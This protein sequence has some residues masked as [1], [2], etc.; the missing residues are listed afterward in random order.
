MKPNLLKFLIVVLAVAWGASAFA[1]PN[2]PPPVTRSVTVDNTGNLYTV[3]GDTNFF[4]K[5]SALMVAAMRLAN[6]TNPWATNAQHAVV[7]DKANDIDQTATNKVN[8]LIANQFLLG[9][10]LAGLTNTGGMYMRGGFANQTELILDPNGGFLINSLD[11]NTYFQFNHSFILINAEPI[12]GGSQSSMQLD[13][14]GQFVAWTTNGNSIQLSGDGNN[15]FSAVDNDGATRSNIFAGPIFGNSGPFYGSFIGTASTATNAQ[16]ANNLNAN[17][18]TTN[19]TVYGSPAK[20]N[21]TVFGPTGEVRTNTG[22]GNNSTWN[23]GGITFGSTNNTTQTQVANSSTGA[24]FQASGL[25]SS[26]MFLNTNGGANFTGPVIASNLLTQGMSPGLYADT[27]ADTFLNHQGIWDLGVR[28][29]VE[30]AVNVFKGGGIWSNVVDVLPLQAMYGATNGYTLMGRTFAISNGVWQARGFG[31]TRSTN[32][33]TLTLPPMTNYSIGI[34]YYENQYGVDSYDPTANIQA[35]LAQLYNPADGGGTILSQWGIYRGSRINTSTTTDYIY[36]QDNVNCSSNSIN[37][38]LSGSFRRDGSAAPHGSGDFY[39]IGYSNGNVTASIN[40]LPATFDSSNFTNLLNLS[41]NASAVTTLHIG[42]GDTNWTKVQN[43]SNSYGAVVCSVVIFNKIID[44]NMARIAYKAMMDLEPYDTAT[45]TSGSSIINNTAGAASG[46]VGTPATNTLANVDAILNPDTLVIESAAPG[47]HMRDW[48]NVVQGAGPYY[49]YYPV[50]NFLDPRKYKIRNHVTDGPRNDAF[51]L[52]DTY[53]N[54]LNWF[55]MGMQPLRTNGVR[56]IFVQTP[57]AYGGTSVAANSNWIQFAL[58]IKTN[59]QPYRFVP[60]ANYVSSNRLAHATQDSPPVHPDAVSMIGHM[61]NVEM[62][63]LINGK[64]SSMTTLDGDMQVA[65]GTLVQDRSLTNMI[66]LP[67]VVQSADGNPA[68]TFD[69][70]QGSNLNASAIS[71]G[72]MAY[73]RL[74]ISKFPMTLASDQTVIGT[75]LTTVVLTNLGPGTYDVDGAMQVWGS[76]TGKSKCIIGFSNSVSIGSGST[77]AY[78]MDVAGGST[79]FT[80]PYNHTG[81][82]GGG[83]PN[84]FQQYSI[85]ETHL[86]VVLTSSNI[87]WVQIAESTADTGT[88]AKSAD[89]IFTITKY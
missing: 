31:E 7:S 5:N 39:I 68:S 65:S 19:L 8:A 34:F 36:R 81:Y 41:T 33:L 84:A 57:W 15:Y 64:P 67:F 21:W 38:M 52:A 66:Q 61:F 35:N 75:T 25:G 6:P 14:F 78:K 85:Y 48:T 12:P 77:Y 13:E 69:L 56:V 51:G 63:N 70:G 43:C 88:T 4:N 79:T 45:E 28:N 49:T 53:V 37:K 46:S 40:G 23:G 9:V 76:A 50:V 58:T 72:T 60:F 54:M 42:G 74:P 83:V 24:V 27:N 30:L 10:N 2:P 80:Y 44:T 87:L 86:K 55:N 29:N 73:A 11:R 17:G 89:T 26:T 16:N 62:D 3:S 18:V 32:F 71:T 59:F 20:T 1:P 22:T 82:Q 47:S